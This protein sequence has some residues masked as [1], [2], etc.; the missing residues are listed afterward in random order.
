[1]EISFHSHLNSNTVIATKFCTWHD[2]CAVVACAKLYCDLMASN[3]ITAR[4]SFHRIWIAGKK[5]L[6]KRAPG[7][8]LALVVLVPY[9]YVGIIIIMS[10][11][12]IMLH[13]I[14][15]Y[16]IVP[17]LSSLVTP[18]VVVISVLLAICEGNP[19]ITGGF[20]S[21]RLVMLG[22]WIPLTHGR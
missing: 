21:E 9:S 20:L 17:T 1:M 12:A 15:R 19:S 8:D 11:N 14:T 3:R 16:V 6:V 5:S 4:R 22:W 2:S 13:W 10:A 7:S 18:E